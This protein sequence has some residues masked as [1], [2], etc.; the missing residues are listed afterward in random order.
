MAGWRGLGALN[1]AGGG[2]A[3]H[4]G[5]VVEEAMQAW[6]DEAFV[7]KADAELLDDVGDGAGVE[8]AD[9]VELAGG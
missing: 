3:E 6:S 8:L 5:E 7:A 9:G 4:G 1:P 2:V